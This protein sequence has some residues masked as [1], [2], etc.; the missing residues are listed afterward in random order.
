MKIGLKNSLLPTMILVGFLCFNPGSKAQSDNK[1]LQLLE[2]AVEFRENSQI[3]EANKTALSAIN[4][5]KLRKDWEHWAEGYEVLYR[6]AR[7]FDTPESLQSGLDYLLKGVFPTLIIIFDWWA[8]EL[9]AFYATFI[10]V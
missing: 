8:L 4:W 5:F 7:H 1:G 2:Q 9:M 3:P 10:N 6:N